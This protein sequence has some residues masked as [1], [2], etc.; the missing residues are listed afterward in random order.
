MLVWL[1]V[2]ALVALVVFGIGQP[3]ERPLDVMLAGRGDADLPCPW[4]YAHTSE[5]DRTCPS[6]GQR[7]G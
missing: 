2:A 1:V 7:F 6:C 3:T 5:D 4:C